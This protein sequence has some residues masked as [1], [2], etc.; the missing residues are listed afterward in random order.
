LAEHHDQSNVEKKKRMACGR[1]YAANGEI[2]VSES[3]RM[4]STRSPAEVFEEFFVPALFQQWGAVV[5]DAAGITQGQRVLDVACG[6]GVLACAAFDRAGASGEVVGLDPNEDMLAVARR[7]SANMEW[8][9]GRA[10][11]LHF[12]DESF[13]AVVSQ[14]GLMFFDDQRTALREMMRVMKPGGRMA[15]AVWDSLDHS[16]GYKALAAPIE[17][18]FGNSVADAFRAPFVLGDP[19]LLLSLCADAGIANA[20]VTRHEG[21][22]H[23]A[24]IESLLYAERM[25]VWTLGGLLDDAQFELLLKE[26]EQAL[27]PFVTAD[28]AIAFDLPALIVTASKP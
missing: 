18:L 26:A 6:T 22:V 17:R 11:S 21:T 5:A 27:Q 10:E 9:N 7:K 3:E 2:K 8:Q 16:P 1:E 13:D 25:C 23:F 15:V 12:S 4:Q 28:G 20:K 19:E 24:S 14:F